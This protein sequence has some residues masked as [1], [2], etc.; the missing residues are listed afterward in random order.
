MLDLKLSDI[1]AVKAGAVKDE[2]LKR[3]NEREANTWA[4]QLR[5]AHAQIFGAR[6][7]SRSSMNRKKCRTIYVRKYSPLGAG[8]GKRRRA[9]ARSIDSAACFG[10]S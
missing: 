5:S 3:L 4:A 6:Q 1:A 9:R 2:G 7:A 10:G 8:P